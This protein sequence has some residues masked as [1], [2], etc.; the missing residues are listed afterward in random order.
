MQRTALTKLI[1]GGVQRPTKES[2]PLVFG[3]FG[4]ELVVR[5]EERDTLQMDQIAT[6]RALAGRGGVGTLVGLTAYRDE[7]PGTAAVGGPA[8]DP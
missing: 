5:V 8:V 3:Q 6:D 4:K 7:G 1:A 2:E